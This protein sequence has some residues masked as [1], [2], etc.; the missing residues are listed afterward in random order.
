MPYNDD[1]DDNEAEEDEEEEEEEDD[2][3]CLLCF[4]VRCA[5]QQGPKTAEAIV[6]HRTRHGPFR[7]RCG[8]RDVRGIGPE[9]FLLAAGFLRVCGGDEPLDATEVHPES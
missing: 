7:G 8:L 3:N 9:N 5:L 6:T 2:G 4:D 1:D